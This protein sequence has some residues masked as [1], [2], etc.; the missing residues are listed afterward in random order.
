MPAVPAAAPAR[1]PRLHASLRGVPAPVGALFWATIPQAMQGPREQR[2]PWRPSRCSPPTAQARFAC[3]LAHLPAPADL[4]PYARIRLPTHQPRLGAA[5][6]CYYN[7]QY[8]RHGQPLVC[9]RCRPGFDV[10][11]APNAPSAVSLCFSPAYKPPCH[12]THQVSLPC[13]VFERQSLFSLASVALVSARTLASLAYFS[14]SAMPLP[15]ELLITLASSFAW[16]MCPHTQLHS[17]IPC[18]LSPFSRDR[19][20]VLL[21]PTHHFLRTPVAL[22]TLVPCFL[23][24]AGAQSARP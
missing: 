9:R 7:A 5:W 19:T 22:A 17:R 11:G 16:S 4:R 8:R 12:P 24:P 10:P 2:G 18:S 23:L 21:D 3:R 13:L 15:H 1:A 20:F 14:T 6:T